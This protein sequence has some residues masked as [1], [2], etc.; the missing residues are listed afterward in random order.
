[1]A[2]IR[3]RHARLYRKS[4]FPNFLAPLVLTS[5]QGRAFAWQEAQVAL[6][7]LMQRFTFVM[8][9]PSYDLKLKQTLTIKPNE[10]YIHAIPR[11]D[12]KGSIPVLGPFSTVVRPHGAPAGA[13]KVSE[14]PAAN[15]LAEAKPLYVLYGSNTGTSE[16]FAQRIAS[17]AASHGKYMRICRDA[18][19]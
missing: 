19:S 18:W 11:T 13:A 1:M 17:A 7:Y 16:A 4:S 8:T 3:L 9:D 12:K 6:V 14:Q 5:R 15:D 2:A 10:F